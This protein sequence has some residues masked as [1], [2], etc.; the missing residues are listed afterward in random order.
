MMRADDME[1]STR[2]AP[3][4]CLPVAPAMPPVPVRPPSAPDLL[5]AAAA[6]D[7]S[8]PTIA[9]RRRGASGSSMRPSMPS[10]EAYSAPRGRR[11]GGWVV[12]FVLMLAVGV[13]GWAVAKPYLVARN[14]GATAQ[15]DPRA[16]A[17]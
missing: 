14:A 2:G 15:L 16:R 9:T 13:V 12:A 10:E 7:A 4:R 5:V 3:R 8:A 11:V 17:S 6:A 1:P